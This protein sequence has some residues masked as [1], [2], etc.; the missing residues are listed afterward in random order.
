MSEPIYIP[1]DDGGLVELPSL[2]F[3]EK[4]ELVRLLLIEL[5]EDGL[6]PRPLTADILRVVFALM[7]LSLK[8]MKQL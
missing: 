6:T 7:P 8:H 2:S 1:T 5:A 4:V 3:G